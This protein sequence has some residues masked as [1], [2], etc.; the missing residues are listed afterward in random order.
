MVCEPLDMDALTAT[1][2]ETRMMRAMHL[3]WK[4]TH[5]GLPMTACRRMIQP[6]GT[7]TR[8]RLD[9]TKAWTEVTCSFCRRDG[10]VLAKE[11]K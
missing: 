10:A 5:D 4:L 6:N 2:K 1:K 8:K 3:Y 9:M 7:G 11:A